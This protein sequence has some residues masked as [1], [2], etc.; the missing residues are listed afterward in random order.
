MVIFILGLSLMFNVVF[1][2]LWIYGWAIQKRINK[3]VKKILRS[4]K[5]PTELYKDWMYSA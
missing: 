2:G 3:N 5:L 4:T 1:I